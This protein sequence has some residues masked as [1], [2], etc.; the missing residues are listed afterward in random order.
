MKHCH[1]RRILL[2]AIAVF[3]LLISYPYL[4]L[5]RSLQHV[6][7]PPIQVWPG[8]PPHY[9]ENTS[10]YKWKTDDVAKAVKNKGLELSELNEGLIIG[11]PAAKE[12]IIFLIPSFGKDIGGIVSSYDSE[13]ALKEATV[14]YSAMNR[15]AISPVWWIFIKDNILFLISRKV[16]EET[17]REYEKTLKEMH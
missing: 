1:N 16:P 3:T 4:A 17:A 2:L 15:D 5:A 10:F 14:Y 11:A 9:S 8:P 6:H 7:P 12:S 13:E